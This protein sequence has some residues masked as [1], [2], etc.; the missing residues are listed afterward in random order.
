MN[1]KHKVLLHTYFMIDLIAGLF[2]KQKINK[3]NLGFLMGATSQ[4]ST[5]MFYHPINNYSIK[6]DILLAKYCTSTLHTAV[7]FYTQLE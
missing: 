2:L 1:N 7:V 3:H 5:C 4:Y 6:G